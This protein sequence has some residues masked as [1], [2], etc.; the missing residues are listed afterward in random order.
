MT[1]KNCLNCKHL[2]FH[3]N[4]D[5]YSSVVGGYVCEKR[6]EQEQLIANLQRDDYLEKAKVCFE[7]KN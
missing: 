1:K 5:E 7:I 3:H 6:E 2:E 4:D